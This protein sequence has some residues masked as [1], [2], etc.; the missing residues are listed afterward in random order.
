MV[1]CMKAGGRTIKQK[2]EEDLFMV[3]V[4]FMKGAG[5][6]TRLTVMEFT[7]MRM[8]QDMKVTGKMISNMGME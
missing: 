2:A 3:T 8:V 7:F 6:E 5:K 4:T 1:L